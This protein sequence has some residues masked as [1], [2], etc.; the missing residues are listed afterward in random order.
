M[1]KLCKPILSSVLPSV[2]KCYFQNVKICAVG[3]YAISLKLDKTYVQPDMS[4][5]HKDNE[6]YGVCYQYWKNRKLTID[7]YEDCSRLKEEYDN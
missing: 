2:L 6:V 4:Y 1:A 5:S 3:K 7:T